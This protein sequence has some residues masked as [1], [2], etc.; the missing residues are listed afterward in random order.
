[1]TEE[2]IDS[3]YGHVLAS[4]VAAGAARRAGCP[5]SCWNP[6]CQTGARTLAVCRLLVDDRDDM[7][8]KALSWALRAVVTHDTDAVREFLTAFNGRLAPR[9]KREVTNKLETGLKNP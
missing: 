9:V 6:V 2:S 8:V 1:M 4:G 3:P 5:P 7:V